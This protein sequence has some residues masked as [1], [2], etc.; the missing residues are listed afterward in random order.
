RSFI[1]KK[2]KKRKR[3]TMAKSASSP[4]N[5]GLTVSCYSASRVLVLG[6]Q[7]V[8]HAIQD[9]TDEASPDELASLDA[10]IEVLKTRID[11]AKAA[12][13]TLKPWHPLHKAKSLI[14][15]QNLQH[16]RHEVKR[17]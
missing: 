15:T 8:Y 2:R 11:T 7:I 17:R 16:N 10:E 4:D 9:P 14:G 5:P 12:E 13:Q 6:K 3:N 1:S